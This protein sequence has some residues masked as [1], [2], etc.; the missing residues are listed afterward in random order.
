MSYETWTSSPISEAVKRNK[1]GS[2]REGCF[3]RNGE[4][5]CVHKLDRAQGH[6][7]LMRSPP[8][9]GCMLRKTLRCLQAPH[10]ALTHS[11]KGV[12]T[13]LAGGMRVSN[14]P[15]PFIFS[16]SGTV[17]NPLIAYCHHVGVPVVSGVAIECIYSSTY[18]VVLH[19]AYRAQC[20]RGIR[21]QD[22][23][24]SSS[25]HQKTVPDATSPHLPH[26]HTRGP[27]TPIRTDVS[28]RA[29][30]LTSAPCV[31]S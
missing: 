18:W 25:R 10:R 19:V 27:P 17:G 28:T 24:M 11:R 7:P 26:T 12:E 13:N 22:S 15:L 23:S 3:P 1:T 16:R 20:P 14:N 30:F 6:P 9:R 29:L 31:A 4:S 21:T 8:G 2:I 5:C